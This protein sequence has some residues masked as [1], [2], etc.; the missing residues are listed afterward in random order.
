M[1]NNIKIK[2]W[3]CK[4]AIGDSFHA[5]LSLI[6]YPRNRCL[7]TDKCDEADREALC[8]IIGVF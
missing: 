3:T 7:F 1:K 6:R 5:P 2:A 4:A 8:D